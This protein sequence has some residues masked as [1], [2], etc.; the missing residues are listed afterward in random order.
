[1]TASARMPSRAGIGGMNPLRLLAPGNPMLPLEHGSVE[2]GR[3]RALGRTIFDYMFVL[4]YKTRDDVPKELRRFSS[5]SRQKSH[6][7]SEGTRLL[8]RARRARG[9]ARASLPEVGAT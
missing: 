6:V 1:M 9:A 4:D 2:V 8:R 3:A 5:T 7:P